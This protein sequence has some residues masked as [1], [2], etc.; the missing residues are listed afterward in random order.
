MIFDK[1]YKAL[2]PTQNSS[3][4]STNY[5]DFAFNDFLS[6]HYGLQFGDLQE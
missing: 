5:I 3:I 4:R 2:N 1:K 6:E